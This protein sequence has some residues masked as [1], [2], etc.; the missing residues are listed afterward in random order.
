MMGDQLSLL[1]SYCE[2]FHWERVRFLNKMKLE[3][4]LLL[5][6]E[7]KKSTESNILSLLFL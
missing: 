6:F 2:K 5:F 4:N 7:L 1:I 3:F